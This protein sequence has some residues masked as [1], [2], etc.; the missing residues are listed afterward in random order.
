MR[1]TN[2]QFGQQY[3]QTIGLDFMLKRLVLPGNTHVALQIWDIGGQSIGSKMLSNYIFGSQAIV[4]C[5]DVTNPQ[6]FS[7]AEDWLALVK[8]VFP[9]PSTRPL[10][11]LLG[12]KS[13]MGHLRAVR[14][15]QHAAFADENAMR[16]FLVSAKTGDNVSAAF[17]RIASE[18]A[19]VAVS[20]PEVD[21]VT[22]VVRAEVVA[23]PMGASDE[24]S[25]SPAGQ[26]PGE[27]DD[28]GSGK[29]KKCSVQ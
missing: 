21:V 7:N 13:D 3:K 10:L 8:K 23:R 16:P 15:E 9:D 28:R 20:K 29:N 27:G 18:L 12:N 4:V 14:S 26:Q 19:G 17:F 24:R 6:S 22:K 25:L 11:A 1:F 2:D 5:Y